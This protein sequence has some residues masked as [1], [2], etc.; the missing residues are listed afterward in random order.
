MIKVVFLIHGFNTGGAETLVKNYA[1]FLDKEK[2]DIAILC[3]E[4]RESPYE[5]ILKDAGIKVIYVC[6]YFRNKFSR[7]LGIKFKMR[8]IIRKIKPDIIH[9][10]LLMNTYIKFSKPNKNTKICY[11]QHYDLSRMTK[12]EYIILKW[13]IKHYKTTIIA[14]ND[15]MC[16][17]LNRKFYVNNT[18]VLNNGINLEPYE[19]KVE[20]D[21]I[22]KNISIPTDAFVIVHVG[23]FAEVKNHKFLVEVFSSI[24]K[25]KN[26]A[27]LLMIGSGKTENNVVEELNGLGLDNSYKIL[28]NRTDVPELLMA[29]DAAIFPSVTEGLGIAVIEMQAAHL[30]V[31]AS[32]GVPQKTKISNYIEYLDLN[33]GAEQ[34]A[35]QLV[36]LIE[37]KEKYFVYLKEWDIKES[38]KRLEKLYTEMINK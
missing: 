6:D 33:I 17:E 2:Y 25:I 28:H 27:Y 18:V 20:K 29:S 10:H 22:R 12:K 35:K 15:D 37:K 8:R 31:V 5:K 11:T 1:L 34:W 30:P 21:K 32:K 16:T 9:S 23:R 13:I 24:K 26:N 14:I 38:V 36:G 3:I 7:K 4:H 19:K